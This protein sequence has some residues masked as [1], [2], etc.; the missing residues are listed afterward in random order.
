MM[1]SSL[2]TEEDNRASARVGPVMVFPEPDQFRICSAPGRQG[3]F[4][5]V[6]YPPDLWSFGTVKGGWPSTRRSGVYIL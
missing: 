1:L 5:W 4:L 3:P 2:G 6:G